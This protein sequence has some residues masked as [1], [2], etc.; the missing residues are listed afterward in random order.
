V[1]IVALFNYYVSVVKDEP[2]KKRFLEMAGVSLGVAG[3]SFMVGYVVRTVL[4][5]EI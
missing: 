2:F 5:V 1:L 3:L 4:G